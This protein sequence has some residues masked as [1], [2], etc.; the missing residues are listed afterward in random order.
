MKKYLQNKI[1]K[2]LLS[3]CIFSL[4]FFTGNAQ[5]APSN[6]AY[7]NANGI[8]YKG[9]GQNSV[10][11]TIND[12]GDPVTYSLALPPAG[13][14]INTITGQ[15][16]WD[17]SVAIGN[18]SLTIVAN[19]SVGS[20][21][22]NYTLNVIS[23]PDDFVMPKYSST[24]KKSDLTYTGT[25]STANNANLLDVYTATGDT[26][27]QRPVFMFMHGG[28]FSTSNDKSQ[29]YVVA[30]CKYMAT[31]GYIAF[32]P[33][34][35][36]G[37]GHTF[38]QNL[39]SCKDMDAC[40]NSIRNRTINYPSSGNYNYNTNF[41]FVGG[42]SAGGHLSC[43][44]V[45]AD[46]SSNYAGF[47][48]NLTNVIAEA[49]GWGS[50]PSS[51]RLYSYSSLTANS[52]PA[53]IVQGSN[54]Q[55]VPIQVSIDLDNA[56]TAAGAFHSFWDIQ[57]ETHDCPNHIPAIC[58]SIAHFY[59]RAWKRAYPQTVNSFTLPIRLGS[60]SV[61]QSDNLITIDWNTLTEENTH[62]F[63]VERSG[64]GVLFKTIGKINAKGNS[65]I[66]QVYAC[67]DNA[68]FL[69][70]R[71]Y[72]RL[73]MVDNDGRFNYSKISS[74][75]ISLT[76]NILSC[77]YP[78]PIGQERWLNLRY[79]ATKSEKETFYVLNAFGQKIFLNTCTVVAGSNNLSFNIGGLRSGLFYLCYAAN[80]NF[81]QG[82][83][84][85]VK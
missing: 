55:T 29:S 44:F 61:H 83:P 35:N 6:L 7:S 24:T 18:Y 26:N 53:F 66:K 51:D 62:H 49:D 34:Y 73:K 45:F 68:T 75:T 12:G 84:F 38:T 65:T 56:L 43:N 76:R 13:I 71:I 2:L 42:G 50:S 33:N 30:F 69:D 8:A 15:I 63:E 72:Y 37:G 46:G 40:L 78:N 57:G 59:N 47:T 77:I 67:H 32:A 60:F 82:L 14:S 79:T 25:Q 21:N 31:C 19:N 41:L 52:M 17:N 11:P 58:D 23:N 85:L 20:T 48:P 10:A 54:D 81:L 28:G 27:T 70:G 5:T 36:V 64:D 1:C 4:S 9:L 74:I 3:A 22:A 80:G 16:T 39:K